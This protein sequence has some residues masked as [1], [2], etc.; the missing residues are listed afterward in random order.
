M[1]PFS[2]STN[3]HCQFRDFLC[4][5]R[6]ALTTFQRSFHLEENLY[7]MNKTM[8]PYLAFGL[9]TLVTVIMDFS[10]LIMFSALSLFPIALTFWLLHKLNRQEM[11]LVIGTPRDYG[12]SLLHPI[13]VLSL[14]TLTAYFMNDLNVGEVKTK[15][16]ILAS[17]VGII[18]VIITEE[19][20][21]RGYLWGAFKDQGWSDKKTLL[22]TSLLFTIWHISAVTSGSEYGLPMQQV[23]VY[24]VNA[25]LMGTAWGLIRQISGSII[26]SSFCHAVWNAFTYELFGFGEKVGSLGITNTALLG[27]EVGWLGLLLN[28]IFVLFLWKVA[29]EKWDGI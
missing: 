17:T 19:G 23:P 24:L 20:F 15:N 5:S 12:I 18:G 16:L 1:V 26:A 25:F 3:G 22:A 7:G 27:P 9:A 21:F 8:L 29:R 11:G 2:K 10:G 6:R 13:F 4:S 14:V 28:G